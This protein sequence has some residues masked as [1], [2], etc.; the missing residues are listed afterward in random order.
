LAGFDTV[1]VREFRSGS[2]NDALPAAPRDFPV[3]TAAEK[4]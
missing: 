1:E 3:G 2:M 4:D